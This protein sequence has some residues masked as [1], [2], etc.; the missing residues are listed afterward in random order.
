MALALLFAAAAFTIAPRS[1]LGPTWLLIVLA[2]VA[3]VWVMLEPRDVDRDDTLPALAV[4]LSA[5]GLLVV[6][7]LSPEL[8]QRQVIWLGISLVLAAAVGPAFNRFRV[9][10][11]YKYI[12]ILLAIVMFAALAIFGQEV[13]G[14]KLWIRVGAVQFE[15]VEVVKLLVVLFMASYLAET[16]DVIAR[17]RPWSLRANAKYLGPLFIGWGTSMAI[18]VFERDLGMASLLLAT[19]ATMLYVAT[20]RLDLIVGSFAVFGVAAFWATKHYHY[21]QARIDVWRH[22]FADPLGAGYQSIQSMFS[23][24]A[25]GLFGTGYHRGTPGY[26][27]DVATDYVYSAWSEEWGLVGAVVLALAFLAIVRRS[28]RIAARQPDLYAKLLATGL[29][30]TLGFQV[31]IILGGVLRLFPLTGITLPFFSYGG[32]SLVTNYV[33]I[34]LIWAV[35]S[36]RRAA[37][38]R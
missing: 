17:T 14:A 5:L 13:N 18:L 29:A 30:A 37:P 16:G 26:I 20:R 21:V 25:G 1:A 15:P 11:A 31:V 19:F 2:V 35:S 6:A 3:A 23:L 7:R 24:A 34:A 27:P 32:S 36:E 8:A 28:L 12:W 38:A 33:L 4:V 9:L 22:P 10:A